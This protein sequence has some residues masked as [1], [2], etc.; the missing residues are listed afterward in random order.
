[1]QNEGKTVSDE[2]RKVRPAY[3]GHEFEALKLR[4][5]DHVH[6]LRVLTQIEQR[7]TVWIVTIQILLAAWLSEHPISERVALGGIVLAD[8]SLLFIGIALLRRHSLRRQEVITTVRNIN[9]ALGYNSKDVYLSGRAINAATSTRRLFPFY[10]GVI[11]ISFVGAI[12]VAL[13]SI[14]PPV[15]QT[16]GTSTNAAA[17]MQGPTADQSESTSQLVAIWTGICSTVIAAVAVWIAWDT[18]RKTTRHVMRL[19]NVESGVKSTAAE[20]EGVAYF[21]VDLKNLGIPLPAMSVVLGFRAKD[22]LGWNRC[23]LRAIDILEETQSQAARGV[24]TGLVCRFGFKANNLDKPTR[25]FL[26]SL[27]N[28][29]EQGALLTVFC[30]GFQVRDFRLSTI[31]GR[32]R[33]RVHAMYLRIIG[34]LGIG[35]FARDQNSWRAKIRMWNRKSLEWSFKRFADALKRAD[36]ETITA[37]HKNGSPSVREVRAR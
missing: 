15:S 19:V 22:G 26:R 30:N 34:W 14:P 23:P 9:D 4:Y 1:M 35:V 20:P 2:N 12:I 25:D 32:L 18:R 6:L 16:M 10:V 17:P 5:E 3:E 24:A 13:G 11:I 8:G 28:V 21:H 31:R 33:D 7:I 29:R 37:S 27:V 36:E